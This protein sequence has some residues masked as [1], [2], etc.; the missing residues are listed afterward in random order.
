MKTE[1]HF[2]LT[3]LRHQLHDTKLNIASFSSLSEDALD[4]LST[5]HAIRPIIYALLEEYP[6][7]FSETFRDKIADFT[8]NQRKL[9]LRFQQ[10]LAHLIT[11]FETKKIAVQPFKGQVIENLLYPPYLPRESGDIDLLFKPQDMPHVLTIFEHLGYKPLIH[12][13]SPFRAVNTEKTISYMLQSKFQYEISYSK[14]QEVLDIHWHAYPPQLPIQDKDFLFEQWKDKP[15]EFVFWT[16]LIHHGAK[17]NWVRLKHLMD[18]ALWMHQFANTSDWTEKTRQIK[19]YGLEKT[20]A[21]GLFLIQKHLDYTIPKVLLPNVFLIDLT[22]IDKIEIAWNEAKSD[23]KRGGRLRTIQKW[24]GKQPGFLNKLTHS[25]Q[26]IAAFSEPNLGEYTRIISF[27]PTFVFLNL[28]SKALTYLFVK[29]LE[30][31][32]NKKKKPHVTNK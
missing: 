27:P 21:Q 30:T 31:W 26:G 15:I 22:E 19:E 20:F 5:F 3:L 6:F 2:L 7:L 24:V 29:P 12:Q 23:K 28:T 25:F 1:V 18:F 9:H 16:L 17:D 14:N 32:L 10:T 4:K 11:I 8:R 13:P